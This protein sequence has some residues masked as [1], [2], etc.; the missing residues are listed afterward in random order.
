MTTNAKIGEWITL[1]D[2]DGLWEILSGKVELYVVYH[3]ARRVFLC[4][5]TTGGFLCA[6][7]AH[8]HAPELSI[9]AIAI[10]ETTLRPVPIDELRGAD[11]ARQAAALEG[12]LTPFF[13]R[14]RETLPPRVCHE[15]P[16]GEKA[17]LPAGTRIA[18]PKGQRLSWL[19]LPR[20]ALQ[21]ASSACFIAAFIN[22]SSINSP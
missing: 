21:D 22:F 11:R 8:I 9:V 14:P 18:V 13:I 6:I 15:L 4:E 20:A 7:P 19:A 1:T 3:A 5:E 10:E 17:S 12:T 2:E 16:P